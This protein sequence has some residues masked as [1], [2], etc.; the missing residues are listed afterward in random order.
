[1]S[2]L[3][4]LEIE[5]GAHGPTVR[6]WGEIDV[7]TAPELRA[8]LAS[9]ADE[10]VVAVDLSGVAFVESSGI[11]VLLAEHQRRDA[12]GAQLVIAGSS[13][14]SEDRRRCRCRRP[15]RRPPG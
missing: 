13:P 12:A 3:L 1:V 6:V 4:S 14:L 11:A 15:W 8:C 5:A 9:L 2:G 7:A 10:P